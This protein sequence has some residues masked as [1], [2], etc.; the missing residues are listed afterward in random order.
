MNEVSIMNRIIGNV[1]FR[2]AIKFAK[3]NQYK[4]IKIFLK[5]LIVCKLIF[6]SSSLS[7]SAQQ[8]HPELIA[9]YAAQY[10]LQVCVKSSQIGENEELIKELQ[11]RNKS[12]CSE[13][14]D[15]WASSYDGRSGLRKYISGEGKGRPSKLS[16]LF[17]DLCND[18]IELKLYKQKKSGKYPECLYTLPNNLLGF[19]SHC[20]HGGVYNN[21]DLR[22]S[23]FDKLENRLGDEL[24]PGSNFK[25]VGFADEGIIFNGID[26]DPTGLPFYSSCYHVL[27]QGG[28]DI[29][30]MNKKFLPE[31]AIPIYSVNQN[32]ALGKATKCP[33]IGFK[34]I[35]DWVY[36][37]FYGTK[38][39]DVLNISPV[40]LDRY[41]LGKAWGLDVN[42]FGTSWAASVWDSDLDIVTEWDAFD[43]TGWINFTHYLSLSG[44]LSFALMES[45]HLNK[46]KTN[47]H[48]R[49]LQTLDLDI[50]S[51]K[52]KSDAK[53]FEYKMLN[54]PSDT[55]NTIESDF[56]SFENLISFYK[57][58]CSNGIAVRTYWR[59]GSTEDAFIPSCWEGTLNSWDFFKYVNN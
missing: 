34:Y 38:L 11:A 37:E 32:F 5:N 44:N 30:I 45:F 17:K 50:K 54:N 18:F 43:E 46:Q 10:K 35:P 36:S 33:W 29:G 23:E 7:A 14:S 26:N 42:D 15:D 47:F 56:I 28:R 4:M 27:I 24:Y 16:C 6:F 41:L 52:L 58:N 55:Q 1:L 8:I 48:F 20:F 22:K 49:T 13:V 59:D 51:F 57:D 53:M 31:R 12:R 9:D 40:I 39:F 19:E 2:R 25:I 3:I 21:R